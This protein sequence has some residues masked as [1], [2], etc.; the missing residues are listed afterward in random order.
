MLIH[1]RNNQQTSGGI[2][3]YTTNAELINCKPLYKYVMHNDNGLKVTN[4]HRAGMS[5]TLAP[6]LF[7]FTVIARLWREAMTGQRQSSWL[8]LSLRLWYADVEQCF[9]FCSTVWLHNHRLSVRTLGL[10]RYLFVHLLHWHQQTRKNGANEKVICFFY[11]GMV[12]YTR[13]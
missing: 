6:V 13:V 4:R 7:S 2:S 5:S 11:Q 8:V 1:W 9:C 10:D 12:R 3:S